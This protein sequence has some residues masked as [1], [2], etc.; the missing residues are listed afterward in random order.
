MQLLVGVVASLMCRH[1]HKT[2]K[3]T[4]IKNWSE[5]TKKVGKKNPFELINKKTHS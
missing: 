4:N 3:Q 2:N 1:R 5:R